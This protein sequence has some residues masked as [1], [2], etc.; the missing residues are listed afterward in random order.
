MIETPVPI[1]GGGPIGLAPAADLG[2]RGAPAMLV[3]ARDNTLASPKMLEV[4]MR[5]RSRTSACATR[6]SWKAS[7]RTRTASANR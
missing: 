6:A 1:A 3:E 2:R 7:C 4:A 5:A